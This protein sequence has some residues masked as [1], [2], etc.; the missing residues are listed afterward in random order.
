[1]QVQ[2]LSWEDPLEK[3]TAGY[4][5]VLAWRIPWMEKP[6]RLQFIDSQRVGHDCS[7]LAHTVYLDAKTMSGNYF[8]LSLLKRQLDCCSPHPV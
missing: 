4:S 7:E 6:G 5:T 2:S 1:M 8:F 3:E